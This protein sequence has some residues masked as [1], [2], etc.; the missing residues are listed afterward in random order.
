MNHLWRWSRTMLHRARGR[1][2]AT[3][4]MCLVIVTFAVAQNSSSAK[5]EDRKAS[6]P[7]VPADS[8]TEGSVRV[9]G[10]TIDYRAIAGTLTVG[11]SD[12]QDAMIGFDGKYLPDATVELSEKPEDRP[13]T[14]RIFY[15]AYFAKNPAKNR[16]ITFLYNGG[17]G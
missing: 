5:S 3:L 4:T 2:I 6:Q 1:W 16:P 15:V 8:I 9:G 13:A 10:Q 7:E 17:P 11:S 14:A 12:P